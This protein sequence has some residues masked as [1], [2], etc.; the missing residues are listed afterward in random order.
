MFV[1]PVSVPYCL[2]WDTVLITRVPWVQSVMSNQKTVLSTRWNKS[3]SKFSTCWENMEL[4]RIWQ[5]SLGKSGSPPKV[6]LLSS[7]NLVNRKS[8]IVDF[9]FSAMLI[10]SSIIFAEYSGMHIFVACIILCCYYTWCANHN[11]RNLASPCLDIS[12]LGAVTYYHVSVPIVGE[13]IQ[14]SVFCI[15]V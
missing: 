6:S 1:L 9:R 11:I 15:S 2:W 12:F 5:M 7:K 10:F 14:Y 8:L 13:L 4:Q 3:I